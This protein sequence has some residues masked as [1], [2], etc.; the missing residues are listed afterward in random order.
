MDYG[1]HGLG[2]GWWGQDGAGD[3]E[4]VRRE[5]TLESGEEEGGVGGGVEVEID[6]VEAVEVFGLVAGVVG[7]EAEVGGGLGRE[8][9]EGID[10]D[11]EEGGVLVVVGYEDVVQGWTGLVGVYGGAWGELTAIECVLVWRPGRIGDLDARSSLSGILVKVEVGAFVKAVVRRLCGRRAVEVVD[12]GEA[13]V[14][15]QY[16]ASLSIYKMRSSYSQCRSDF[17]ARMSSHRGFSP[18]G[19]RGAGFALSWATMYM[20][21]C[22]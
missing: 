10:C 13:V 3:G 7:G 17:F 1:A 4:V 20:K 6:C 8:R 9:G 21:L 11:G 16:T 2:V 18:A 14:Y 5:E 15:C 22:L 19:L 12:V